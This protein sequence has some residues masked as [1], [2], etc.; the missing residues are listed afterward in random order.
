MLGERPRRGRGNF[1]SVLTRTAYIAL[2]VASGWLLFWMMPLY[3]DLATTDLGYRFLKTLSVPLG[4]GLCLAWAWRCV[5]ALAKIAIAFEA[6][7]IATRLGWLY[8]ESPERLCSSYLLSEQR[9]VGQILLTVSCVSAA[10]GLLWGVFGNFKRDAGAG[11][12][13]RRAE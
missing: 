2:I 7:A 12:S 4:I 6:W 3:L 9:A 11:G 10:V 13:L 5:G 1:C 8:L